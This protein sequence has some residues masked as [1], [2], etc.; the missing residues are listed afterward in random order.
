LN[1]FSLEHSSGFRIK[2]H[3]FA[4]IY[5]QWERKI[6]F[7]PGSIPS[8]LGESCGAIIV[9]FLITILLHTRDRWFRQL[10]LSWN[11]NKCRSG[12]QVLLA[13]SNN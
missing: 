12:P 5:C 7:V 2:S 8:V 11:N 6:A 4:W 10:C 13:G 9:T 1:L 3:V